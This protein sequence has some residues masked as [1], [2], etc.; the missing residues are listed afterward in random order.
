MA[1]VVLIYKGGDKDPQDIKLYR[2]VSLLSVVGKVFERI[3]TKRLLAII[4]ITRVPSQYLVVDKPCQSCA[5]KLQEAFH[6]CDHLLYRTE[7]P[8]I[9]VCKHDPRAQYKHATR[10]TLELDE[11]AFLV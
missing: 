6:E 8:N 11:S 7:H 3:V 10:V 5:V 4:T 2:P 1:E 9:F